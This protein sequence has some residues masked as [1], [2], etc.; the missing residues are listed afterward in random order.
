M[1]DAALSEIRKRCEEATPGPWFWDDGDY[2]FLTLVEPM[3]EEV[4][5]LHCRDPRYGD[6]SDGRP[7]PGDRAFMAH[8]RMDVPALLAEVDR[9]K[10]KYEKVYEQAEP[11]HVWPPE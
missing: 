5:I 9:L 7:H 11:Q 6:D 10:Q 1:T 3:P 8:A 4:G 2:V